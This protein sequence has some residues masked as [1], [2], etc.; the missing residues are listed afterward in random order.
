M[1]KNNN[2][3]TISGKDAVDTAGIPFFF[4]PNLDIIYLVFNY[5]FTLVGSVS[6]IT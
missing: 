4:F 6:E 1:K 2:I 3:K 5:Y